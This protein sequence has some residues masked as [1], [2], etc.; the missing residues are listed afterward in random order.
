MFSGRCFEKLTI[1]RHGDIL[2]QIAI[3]RKNGANPRL[4]KFPYKQYVS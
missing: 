2:L 1:N 3:D 4:S